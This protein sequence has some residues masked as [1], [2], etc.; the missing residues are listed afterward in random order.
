MHD[1]NLRLRQE[2]LLV[3]IATIANGLD[4][5]KS[6]TNGIGVHEVAGLSVYL[7]SFK[8]RIAYFAMAIIHCI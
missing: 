4:K 7:I 6:N 3:E 8:H 5:K 1:G 2:I